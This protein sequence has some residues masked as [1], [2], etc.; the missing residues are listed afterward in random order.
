MCIDEVGKVVGFWESG[1]EK[2]G[3]Q[4][5]ALGRMIGEVDPVVETAD[6]VDDKDGTS[7]LLAEEGGFAVSGE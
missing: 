6:G 7:D 1:E 5:A 3:G 2:R 4:S